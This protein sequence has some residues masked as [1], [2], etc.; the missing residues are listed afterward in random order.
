MAK[1][2]REKREKARTNREN[3]EGPAG[4]PKTSLG[5][6]SAGG[7]V[8]RAVLETLKTADLY[9]LL[10]LK[11]LPGRSKI[12]KKTARVRVLAPLVTATDLAATG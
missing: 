5:G 12:R 3:R 11:N 4:R 2:T 1:R 9:K 8:G 6:G 10:V 7:T